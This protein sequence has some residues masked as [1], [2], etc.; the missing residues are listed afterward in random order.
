MEPKII[1][2]KSESTK[3][4]KETVHYPSTAQKPTSVTLQEPVG[5][6]LS[7]QT[8]TCVQSIQLDN[9]PPNRSLIR[10]PLLK[11]KELYKDR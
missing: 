9:M 7:S 2:K 8:M 6:T 10:V 4:P 3:F 5:V 1:T 11:K